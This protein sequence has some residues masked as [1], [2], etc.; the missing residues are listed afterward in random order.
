MTARLRWCRQKSR[1]RHVRHALA[2]ACLP[3]ITVYEVHGLL[4]RRAGVPRRG[5]R[6][7]S[8]FVGRARELG[9][10]HERLALTTSGQGQALGITGEPGMGKSRLLA[11]FAQSLGE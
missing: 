1:E 9:L 2:T 7:L 6:P 5:A 11:E 8:R 4:R 3:P 10:L